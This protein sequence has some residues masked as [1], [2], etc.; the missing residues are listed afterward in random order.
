MWLLGRKKMRR[1]LL[2]V[3]FLSNL[4]C[5]SFAQEKPADEPNASPKSSQSPEKNRIIPD[6]GLYDMAG[7]VWEW[8]L[9]WYAADYC[10]HGPKANP[11]NSDSGDKNYRVC[12]GGSWGL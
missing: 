5:V 1:I 2:V 10:A 7:N 12:R 8:C 6:L 9:D 4:N 3:L 11:I